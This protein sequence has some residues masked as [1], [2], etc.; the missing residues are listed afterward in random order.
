MLRIASNSRF[1]VV[2]RLSFRVYDKA[3]QVL[4]KEIDEN[5][6][7]FNLHHTNIFFCSGEFLYGYNLTT[8]EK[9]EILSSKSKVTSLFSK[10]SYLYIGFESG[11]LSIYTFNDHIFKY[12][13]EYRHG[14]PIVSLVS[15]GLKTYVADYR[16]RITVYPDNRTFDFVEPKLFFKKYLFCTSEKSVYA[17]TEDAFGLVFSIPD[18]IED[19]VFSEE[20]GLL[21]IKTR[22]GVSCYDMLGNEKS[23][24]TSRDFIVIS[25]NGQCLIVSDREKGLDVEEA[26]VSD[27]AMEDIVFKRVDIKEKIIEGRDFDEKY[28]FVDNGNK[29]YLG[30]RKTSSHGDM[31][32][33]K[34]CAES[35][36]SQDDS[37]PDTSTWKGRSRMEVFSDDS[38]LA[39]IE[40]PLKKFNP[41]TFEQQHVRL[42]F[43][44][45]EGFMMSLESE[46]AN[47]ICIHYHD[48]SI[49]PIEIRDHMKSRLGSFYNDKFVLSN[50]QVVNFNNAWSKDIPA[51]LLGVNN[52]YVYVF[53]ENML[54]IIDFA[55][56][57][58]TELY[59]PDFHSFCCS[60]HSI[61]VFTK[62]CI[63]LVR[64]EKA[65]YVPA[66]NV[67]FGCFYLEELYVKIKGN[68]FKL[69]NGMLAKECRADG[70]PLTINGNNLV[71]L[72]E[73]FTLLPKPLVSYS[74][75]KKQELE[76][77]KLVV[78]QSAKYN[79]LRN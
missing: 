2:Y 76:K 62:N 75:I 79:P 64:H 78:D 3:T 23:H 50:G 29:K 56:A 60:E 44:S 63:M 47:Q 17:K 14:G 27:V 70:V 25:R 66:C 33:R 7:I 61:A 11:L 74:Q 15:D 5:C 67:E 34:L 31:E 39:A 22:R 73:P 30:K 38:E 24:T 45:R 58:H 6:Y 48:N 59:V 51:S 37:K 16:S 36:G 46:L 40:T 65:E 41:S 55:G 77:I 18:T 57:V 35:Q 32:N 49:E 28:A 20:G 26:Y 71:A 43:F 42:L 19:L 54:T 8:F 53:D 10:D 12:A 72:S 52:R 13:K 1:I 9:T 68:L 4:L 69:K 21:F